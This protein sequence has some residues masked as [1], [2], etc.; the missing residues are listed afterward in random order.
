MTDTTLPSDR[1]SPPRPT[2]SDGRP[3]RLGIEIEFAALQPR[4]AAQ[5]I[6]DRFGGTVRQ[7]D[8]HRYRIDT[9]ADGPFTV[10][11]DARY[12]HPNQKLDK[13]EDRRPWLADFANWIREIDTEAARLIG[14]VGADLIPCEIVCPPL[15]W[16]RLD[17]L[18][19]LYRS[20]GNAG[21]EGTGDGLLYAFGLHMNIETAS[22]DAAS[23][24]PVLQAY[25]LL[26]PWLRSDIRVDGTRRVFPYIDPFPSA[27]LKRVC[28]PGYAP[29][30]NRLISDYLDFNDTRN[31]ELDMLPIFAELRPAR[32]MRAV[33]D[34][35]VNARPAY[36]WRLPNAEFGSREAGPVAEWRRWLTVERLAEDGVGLKRACARFQALDPLSFDDSAERLARDLGEAYKP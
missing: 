14:D 34:P 5:L 19:S 36:H 32:V 30:T 15:P 25:L 17:D 20:I 13:I 1:L 22:L 7:D 33:D 8:P 6:A 18:E 26:S 12:A 3:R 10:E 11:L 29:D 31:R 23:I 35:R 2:V 21:A 16:T 27:Y 9:D 28:D 24:A 4:D